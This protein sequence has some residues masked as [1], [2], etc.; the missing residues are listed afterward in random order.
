MRV[1]V[2]DGAGDRF[3]ID[4]SKIVS[5]NTNSDCSGMDITYASGD[6]EEIYFADAIDMQDAFDLL[7][8]GMD[9]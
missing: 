5:M 1:I 2:K 8:A 9:R 7:A 3:A 6:S 4:P